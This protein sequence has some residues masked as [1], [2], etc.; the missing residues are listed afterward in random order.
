M[1]EERGTNQIAGKRYELKLDTRHYF[2]GGRI[3]EQLREVIEC[4]QR[5]ETWASY[6][7]CDADIIWQQARIVSETTSL[8]FRQAV[9]KVCYDMLKSQNSAWCCASVSVCLTPP[10]SKPANNR[11]AR[12][13]ADKERR[14][15][16]DKRK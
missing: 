2:P 4:Y 10:K 13:K 3:P 9:D 16:H 8:T 5:A 6:L 14:H 11:A 15:H 12:R 7:E 1:K